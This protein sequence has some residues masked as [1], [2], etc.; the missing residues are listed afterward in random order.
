MPESTPLRVETYCY[1]CWVLFLQYLMQCIAESEYGRCVET[2]G[3]DPGS[4]YQGVICAVYQRVCVQKKKFL[5]I[6]W[7]CSAAMGVPSH[8]VNKRMRI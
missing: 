7:L 3:S 8:K 5:V 2:L 1:V 6:H 4:L